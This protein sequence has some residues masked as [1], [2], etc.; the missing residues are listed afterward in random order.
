MIG[1]PGDMTETLDP[2]RTAGMDALS[3]VLRV[4][5]LTGGVFLHADFFA[6]W[7][8]AARV[9][10]EHCTPVLGPAS[11]L[12]LYHYV[13]EGD[14]HIRVDGEDGEGLTIGAGEV[15]LLPRNDLHLMGSDLSLP[16]VV[17]TDII[18]PP[19][20]GG[21][22]S[23]HHGGTGG[24]TRM[25]CGFLG[26]ASA[27]GNPVISTLPSL[28][29]LNVEQ[30]G[31]AEWIRSTFQYAAEEVSAGRP[32]SE[33]VLAKLSEL[34]F[35][36]AVRR[37]A[38]ALPDGQTGWLAGLREPYV[39]RALALLHRDVARRW[40]VDNL[41]REVGL[42]RS[43][44]ADRFIRLI[45]VPPMHYLANW[46]MQVAIQKLRN[47]SASLAQVAEIVGY[48]SEAAFSRAFKRAFGA[49]P[50]TWRRSNS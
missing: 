18:Q 9:A 19:K 5:H 47:T 17:G 14:L 7:C 43:A 21:L 39:A 41:G 27:E 20:D 12:I 10:P 32:G 31:A 34:L 42:S 25:I 22:F 2:G 16:P 11:H 38:E 23:I 35:V 8:M 6:P 40:T 48:D 26:C 46:R 50:A 29:K 13:V 49:A 3:D 4:A 15:V 37:Y 24:R 1:P 33:T 30:G 45:G 36:E 28:L 44:L